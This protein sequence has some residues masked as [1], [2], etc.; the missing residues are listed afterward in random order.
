MVTVK[1]LALILISPLKLAFVFCVIAILCRLLKRSKLERFFYGL[2]VTWLMVFSQPY[3]ADLLLFPLEYSQTNETEPGL[4]SQSADFVLP[5]AC[6]YQTHTTIPEI[7]RWPECSL[8]RMLMAKNLAHK[9]HAELVVTGGFFLQDETVNYAERAAHFFLQQGWPDNKLHIQRMGTNT[10]EELTAVKSLIND[11]SIIIV[12]SAT[13]T[14]R[15]KRLAEDLGINATV[16]SASYNSGGKL[17]PYIRLPSAEAL[18]QSQS[19]F[20]EYLAILK[21]YLEGLQ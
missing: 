4:S 2:S 16:I 12:T 15:V 18:L 3:V 17:K 8:L 14:Y 11:A 19:A 1:S 5:L 13:H 9:Y 7:S 20:Y 10:R 21:Y 6:Y